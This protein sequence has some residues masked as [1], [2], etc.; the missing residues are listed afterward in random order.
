M[1]KYDSKV[2]WNLNEHVQKWILNR[3]KFHIELSKNMEL[4][5]IL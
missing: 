2:E 5:Q 4:V 3:S 1:A